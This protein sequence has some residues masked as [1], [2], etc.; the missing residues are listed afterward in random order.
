[1]V[2]WTAFNSTKK[3]IKAEINAME[4]FTE[5]NAFDEW[6]TEVFLDYGFPVGIN[7]IW[8]QMFHILS[9]RIV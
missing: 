3:N 8:T 1:M 6:R 9:L 4:S 2:Y 7:S 5:K